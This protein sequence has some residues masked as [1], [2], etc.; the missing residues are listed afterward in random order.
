MVAVGA[1]LAVAG[2]GMTGPVMLLLSL[3]SRT[4]SS[5]SSSVTPILK[6]QRHLSS[7]TE[8]NMRHEGNSEE[9]N[10]RRLKL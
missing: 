10:E 9:E 7:K 4:A 8:I 1:L 2:D 3:M 6:K 5:S